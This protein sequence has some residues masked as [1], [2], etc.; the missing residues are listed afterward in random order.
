MIIVEREKLF[1]GYEEKLVV[2]CD[3]VKPGFQKR[4][5]G[6]QDGLKRRRVLSKNSS[7]TRCE[8]EE[9]NVCWPA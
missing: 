5:Q 1:A 6:L 4:L 9:T 7:N 8:F 3:R 2:R